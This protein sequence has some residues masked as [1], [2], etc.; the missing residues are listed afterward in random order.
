MLWRGVVQGLCAVL[1][2][3]FSGCYLGFMSVGAYQAEEF[4]IATAQKRKLSKRLFAPLFA[5][6]C[7]IKSFK[8]SSFQCFPSKYRNLHVI[9][10]LG[11]SKTRLFIYLFFTMLLTPYFPQTPENTAVHSIFLHSPMFQCRW[12]IKT[13][14]EPFKNIFLQFT[15][16]SAQSPSKTLVAVFSQNP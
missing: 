4:Q 6:F 14:Q 13:Y 5:R 11:R 15:R 3:L 16:F 8:T 1:Q 2:V 9:F 12:P 10:G 7:S